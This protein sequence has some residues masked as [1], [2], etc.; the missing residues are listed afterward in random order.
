MVTGTNVVVRNLIYHFTEASWCIQGRW[1]GNFQTNDDSMSTGRLQ[2]HLN[3][4][5]FEI[6]A[7][8][9]M[10]VQYNVCGYFEWVSVSLTE[11]ILQFLFYFNLAFLWKN[12]VRYIMGTCCSALLG[13]ISWYLFM[14]WS[15]KIHL[16]IAQPRMKYLDILITK[17]VI[18]PYSILSMIVKMIRSLV[19]HLK[20]TRKTDV[21]FEQTLCDLLCSSIPLRWR[22][23]GR[24]SVSNHQP[25][26]CLLYRLF[27]RRSKK[28]PK[29]RVTGLCVGNSPGTGE[30]PSQMA[31]NAEN[32]SIWWRHHGCWGY[33][34]DTGPCCEA[35]AT[36]ESDLQMNCS[37][38]TW[39]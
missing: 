38:L 8:V 4:N 17:F 14:Q 15:L 3:E 12:I 2:I 36:L 29:L 1:R 9:T 26:D 21:I 10:P 11:S 27:R 35:S 37:D 13:L 24:D 34:P 20:K 33:Y 19:S 31:S 32:V 16:K 18:N 23:N 6:Q 22:H 5:V 25:H 7:F 39:S 30:F 28:T